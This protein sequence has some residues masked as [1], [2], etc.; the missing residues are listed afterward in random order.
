MNNE[1]LKLLCETNSISSFE[2]NIMSVIESQ[3]KYNTEVIYDQL[4]SMLVKNN[5]GGMWFLATHVDEVGFVVRDIDQQGYI[6][7]QNIGSL[8]SHQL[9]NQRMKIITNKQDI[10]GIISAPSSHNLTYENRNKVLGIDKLCL[11]CGFSSLQEAIDSGVEIGDQVVFISEYIK[12]NNSSRVIAKALDNRISCYCGLELLRNNFGQNFTLAFTVQEEVGL[13]GAKT[14]PYILNLPLCLT[15]DTTLAGDT[16]YD[17]ND[18]K[19]GGGVVISMMDSNSVYHRGLINYLVYLCNKYNIKYQYAVFKKGGT[20][21]GNIHKSLDGIIT[22][23]LSV[24]MRY[25]HSA[26]GMVDLDDVSETL[27]LL[28]AFSREINQEEF[29]KIINYYY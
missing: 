1:L 13:R 7:I 27:K 22:T 6:Y 21:A 24:P 17:S 15:L 8:W 23:S 5:G 26:N 2:N 25:M 18:T 3:L 12:L 9:L 14:C 20:D 4:G 16:I 11:D 29:E 28:D 19:L 10:I